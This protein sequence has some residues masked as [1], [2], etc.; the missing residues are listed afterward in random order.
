MRRPTISVVIPVYNAEHLI[1][2]V[3]APVI[4]ALQRQEI[5]EILV[6]DDCSTDQSMSRVARYPFI[7][8]MR[9]TQQSG[10]GGARNL[11]APQAI[12]E[13]LW[14]VD[15]DVIIADDAAR[16]LGQSFSDPGT[17]AVMGSYDDTPA[18]PGFL[19][20]YKNLVHHF[21]HHNAKA[22]ASTFWAGC[23]AVRKDAFLA[24]NGFDARTYKYPSIEDIDLGYRLRAAGGQILLDK[25]IQGKHLKV[26][27]L[28][29]LLHTEIFRRA[30]PWSQLMLRRGALTD[31]LNVG[32]GERLRAVLVI[33]LSLAILSALPGFISWWI[34]A[35][36][37][38][39]D[40]I[41]SRSFLSFFFR[42]RGAWFMVRA[43]LMHRLYYLY[44]SAAFAWAWLT[45][46][47][48]R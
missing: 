47:L 41:A 18:A 29:N 24:I 43:Y 30:I 10:P 25:S 19:S 26:W 38:A 7:R 33:L 31:D 17:V 40:V 16:L 22:Q 4:A 11:A 13:I 20:Q 15:S 46:K 8:T 1:D 23:G 6:V 32:R 39:L 48:G 45:V 12:G 42:A 3:F 21:Y 27:R 5:D 14:F 35:G 28:G 9:T 2:R 34:P 37:F 36:L 44:S